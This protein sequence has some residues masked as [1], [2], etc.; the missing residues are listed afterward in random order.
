MLQLLT[1][2]KP[3]LQHKDV[4]YIFFLQLGVWRRLPPKKNNDDSVQPQHKRCAGFFSSGI[5]QFE[6]ETTRQGCETHLTEGHLSEMFVLQTL[7]KSS[8][9]STYCKVAASVLNTVLRV[10]FAVSFVTSWQKAMAFCHQK[11]SGIVR[12]AVH[13]HDVRHRRLVTATFHGF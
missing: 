4:S 1:M 8:H 7:N 6:K 10:H 11:L 12:D 9:F 3:L 2:F 13:G 5:S